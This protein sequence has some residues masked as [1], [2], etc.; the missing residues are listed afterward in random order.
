MKEQNSNEIIIQT[1]ETNSNKLK[2]SKNGNQSGLLIDHPSN[3]ISLA[4]NIQISPTDDIAPKSNKSKLNSISKDLQD[5]Q[6]H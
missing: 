2:E 3:N 1:K 5:E 4:T 6:L